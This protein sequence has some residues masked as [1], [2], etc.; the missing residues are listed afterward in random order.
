M[1]LIWTSSGGDICVDT[2][3]TVVDK[4]CNTGCFGLNTVWERIKMVIKVIKRMEMIP[5]T[6]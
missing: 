2:P 6:M 4:V 3:S 5:E 1:K